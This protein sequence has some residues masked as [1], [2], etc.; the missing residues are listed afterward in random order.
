MDYLLHW[1]T[2]VSIFGHTQQDL[3]KLLLLVRVTVPVQPIQEVPR[4]LSLTTTTIVN[5]DHLG[6][7]SHQT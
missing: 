4:I 1:T 6:L 5:Q 7:I 3:A 2:L